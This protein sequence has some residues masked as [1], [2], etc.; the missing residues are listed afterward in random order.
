VFGWPQEFREHHREAA[1]G[2]WQRLVNPPPAI[3]TEREVGM[4]Q[5]EAD[6]RRG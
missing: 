2:F 5:E 4:D 6:G 1:L 3:E